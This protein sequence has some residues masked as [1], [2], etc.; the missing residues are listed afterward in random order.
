MSDDNVQHR[1][2]L[3]EQTCRLMAGRVA[4]SNANPQQIITDHFE[5]TYKALKE[6]YLKSYVRG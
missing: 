4:N 2:F 5:K 3:F 6:E 1:N